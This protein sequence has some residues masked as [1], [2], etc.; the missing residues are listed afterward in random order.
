MRRSGIIARVV[1]AAL[2]GTAIPSAAQETQGTSSEIASLGRSSDGLLSAEDLQKLVAPVALYPDTLLVQVLIAA[3]APLDVIMADRLLRDDDAAAAPAADLESRIKDAAFEPNVEVLAIAFPQLIREMAINIEWTDAVGN[4]MLAQKDDVLAA[5]QVMRAQAIHSGALSS[6][7]E[8]VVSTDAETKAIIVQPANPAIVYVP[9]YDPEVVYENPVGG[10]LAT[11]LVVF[12]TLALMDEIFD[13]D[14]DWGNYWG[15]RNCGGWGNRP[16]ISNPDVDI[17]INGDVNFGNRVKGGGG[18]NPDNDR[19]IAARE[20]L[21]VRRGAS[22]R[23]MPGI[24][25]PAR[26]ADELRSQLGGKSERGAIGTR[27]NRMGT[28]RATSLRDRSPKAATVRAPKARVKPKAL[29]N[30]RAKPSRDRAQPKIARTKSASRTKASSKRGA[31]A[32][33]GSGGQR[34]RK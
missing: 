14:D 11:G 9:E 24:E 1:V 5:V 34:R 25:R 4:A 8:Q 7:P 23:P 22:G 28:D 32:V 2:L 12:G 26:R 29:P 18:W 21:A 20:R 17:D 30:T 27:E 13:D 19:V 33:R 15:C 3:T 10:A 6:T 31:D 16:I